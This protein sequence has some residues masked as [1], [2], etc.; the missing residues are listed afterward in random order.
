MKRISVVIPTL[1]EADQ[2]CET[3][4]ALQPMRRAGHEIIVVDGG[5]RDNTVEVAGP[6]A[7]LVLVGPRG[8]AA[9]MR[10]GMERASGELFWML[11]ADTRVPWRALEALDAAL[12]TSGNCW[13]R[14]DVRLSG[15]GLSFRVIEFM[16][17]LRSRV[18]GI[19][20]GD[21]GI[22]VTR[23]LYE[24]VGGMPDLP[25]MEDVELSRRLR[26]WSRPLC[27]RQRVVTSSRRW[28]RGGVLRTVVLMWW[29]RLRY[30]LGAEASDL[31]RV[32]RTQP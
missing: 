10:L 15:Y 22:F 18:S 25:L 21:Q 6:W 17:N 16:M 23:A 3:L 2:I 24:C 26:R 20:T 5:S 8:R 29:L 12:E 31:A 13:G 11:H 27:L 14:F 32:Y 19:A 1:D 9:Q 30:T 4:R 28:E 7:D